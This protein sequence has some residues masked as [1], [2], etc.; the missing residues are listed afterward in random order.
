MTKH[1]AMMEYFKPKIRELAESELK[2]NF[3][4]ETA[5][6]ISFITNYGGKLLKKYFGGAEKEYGFS[7]IVVKE[8]SIDDDDLNLEV[9]NFAQ[10]FMDWLEQQNRAKN[11]PAFPED[12]Q[13]KKME[14]LQNMPNLTGVNP[15][16]GLARYMLQC[17]VIYYEKEC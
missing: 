12:C 11:Y 1:D 6:S 5:N 16:A 13:I 7:I 15:E 14:N 8:Y 10:K 2:L 4:P 9:M 3:S 17:R